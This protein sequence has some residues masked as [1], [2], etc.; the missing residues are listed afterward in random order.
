M[1]RSSF[2]LI[3][4]L[5]VIVIIGILAAMSLTSLGMVR[6]KAKDVRVKS[7]IAQV[8]NL[9]MSYADVGGGNLTDLVCSNATCKNFDGN[10]NIEKDKIGELAKDIESQIGNNNDGLRIIVNGGSW[11]AYSGLPSAV[12]DVAPKFI[13][14]DSDGGIKEYSANQEGLLGYWN[15]NEVSGSVAYD[16]SGDG[17]DGT[18]YNS[19]LA[20]TGKFGNAIQFNGAGGSSSYVSTPITNTQTTTISMWATNP[21]NGT[22]MWK[23]GNVDLYVG[24]S[25][26]AYNYG[27]NGT[28]RVFCSVPADATDGNF[29]HYAVTANYISGTQTV[30]TNM[31][32]DGKLCNTSGPVIGGIYNTVVPDPSGGFY[33]SYPSTSFDWQ[34]KI[35]DVRVYSRELLVSEILALALQTP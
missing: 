30:T 7:D 32:Y 17:K 9:I 34:G 14:A 11:K 13:I 35:D 25:T 24:G 21:T 5:V 6:Q 33:F 2:T 31:Y 4:L 18:I 3:E 28:L 1:K 23:S 26:F 19:N 15:L 16:S 22:M 8:R 10:A 29:H 12:I 27:G 20:V